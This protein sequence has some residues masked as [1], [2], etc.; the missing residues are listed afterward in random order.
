MMLKATKAKLESAHMFYDAKGALIALAKRD[1]ITGNHL[2][3]TVKEMNSSNIAELIS[4][5]VEILSPGGT[6]HAG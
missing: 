4:D 6:G 5:E 2:M 1:E 3:Y